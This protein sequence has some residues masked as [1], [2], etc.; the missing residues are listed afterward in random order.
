MLSFWNFQQIRLEWHIRWIPMYV[1]FCYMKC[2]RHTASIFYINCVNDNVLQI[3]TVKV[4]DP[5]VHGSL[6]MCLSIDNAEYKL[7]END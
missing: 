6:N 7:L 1:A 4:S 5:I 3:G 2:Q